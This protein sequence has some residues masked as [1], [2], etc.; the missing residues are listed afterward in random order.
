MLLDMAGADFSWTNFFDAGFSASTSSEMSSALRFLSFAMVDCFLVVLRGVFLI[1]SSGI[2]SE[3]RWISSAVAGFSFNVRRWN[4]GLAGME[5]EGLVDVLE[6]V[7]GMAFVKV[8]AEVFGMLFETVF[9][10]VLADI[11]EPIL[12][13]APAEGLDAVLGA[14]LEAVLEAGLGAV[15]GAVFG[16]IFVAVLEDVFTRAF[17]SATSSCLN[18][19]SPSNGMLRSP[20]SGGKPRA[21]SSSTCWWERERTGG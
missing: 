13:E 21:V 15:L 3:V 16:A 11:L 12:E 18:W 4:T 1:V 6:V 9:G 7:V 5:E 17:S 8:F 20:M 2:S 14:V 19:T 10:P